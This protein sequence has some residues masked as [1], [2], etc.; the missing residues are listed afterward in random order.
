[1]LKYYI[2]RIRCYLGKLWVLAKYLNLTMRHVNRHEH[3]LYELDRKLLIMNKTL[4]DLLI[5][6]FHIWNMKLLSLPRCKTRLNRIYSSIH[7]LQ[8]DTDSFYEFMRALASEQLNLMIMPPEHP[9]RYHTKG[10]RWHQNECQIK[11][12][13][14][15][16]VKDI[17][18]YYG[19]TK[20][21]AN[22]FGRLFD[23]HT[24]SAFDRYLFT[25]EYVQSTKLTY[26]CIQ[27]FRSRLNMN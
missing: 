8:F 1:M 21:T 20:L 17:W 5:S 2:I 19:T 6:H 13:L 27:N 14:M 9:M 22:S 12:T 4:Q 7:G 18:S 3:M 23:A 25:D 11:I 16:P 26:S 24:Y 10:T 15:I